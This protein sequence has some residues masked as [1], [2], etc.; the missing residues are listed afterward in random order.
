MVGATYQLF[1]LTVNNGVNGASN[2]FHFD[3]LRHI[4]GHRILH[5][6][7]IS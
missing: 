1:R 3:A 5:L 7:L 6:N 4:L 2:F